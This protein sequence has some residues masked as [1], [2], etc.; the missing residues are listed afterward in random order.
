[1]HH[2]F[3]I[4]YSGCVDVLT[5]KVGISLPM[6]FEEAKANEN[7][8]QQYAAI[9]DTGA[10]HSAIT[11]KVAD[12]LNL[13]PIRSIETHHAGGASMVN[14]YMVN[15]TLPN[16][17]MAEKVQVT[18]AILTESTDVPEDEQLRAL[19]GMDIIGAGDLA[20]TNFDNKTTMSFRTPSVEMIDFVPSARDH[21]VI[22]G[23][24]RQQRRALKAKKK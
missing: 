5:T 16:G 4:T 1:M 14:L 6:T 11:K 23:G 10:T 20:V 7:N 3:T 2:A 22:E 15:I 17:I 21:N 13:K 12:N 8:I 24:N 19:I 18:E 9:W